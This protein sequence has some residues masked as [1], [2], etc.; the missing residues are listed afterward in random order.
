MSEEE[1]YIETETVGWLQ[2]IVQSLV[3]VILGI[4]LFVASFFVLYWNEGRVDLSQVAQQAI[5]IVATANNPAAEGKLVS[6]TGTVTSSELLGDNLY[7]QPG[8]YLAVS[9]NVEMFA[10]KETRETEKKR[11]VGGSETRTTTYSYSKGWERN[12]EDS[13]SFKRPNG[14]ENP[15]KAIADLNERVSRAQMGIYSLEMSN[16]ELP[17]LAPV[18]LKEE[19]LQLTADVKQVGNYLFQGNGTMEN[20]LV[21]DLR[22]KYSALK[23]GIEATV[24]GL[25]EKGNRISAYRHQGQNQLYRLFTETRTEAIASL[26]TE[27]KIWTWVLRLI[28]FVMMWCGLSMAAEPISVVLDVIPFFGD[29][30]RSI[31][32]TATLLVAFVLSS[33][34]IIVSMLLHN[35]VALAIAILVAVIGMLAIRQFQHS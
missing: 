1:E 12:P 16:I 10:W 31:T 8:K 18:Q 34:T 13:S 26:K 20:P 9:R 15:P 30:S 11:N 35:L 6:V 21:G 4:I 28:G 24:F 32:G 27:H 25:L 19:N 33:I 17:S 22:I 29:I 3:G 14:R 5:E 23:N 7:L 2:R